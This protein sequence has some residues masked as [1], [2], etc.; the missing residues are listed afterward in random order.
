M[1]REEL[2]K[3][4]KPILFNTEMVKA[5]LDDCKTVTR[6]VVKLH[7]NDETFV[8]IKYLDS[9]YAVFS[10]GKSTGY[11]FVRLPCRPLD[12]LYVREAWARIC[13][14]CEYEP[15]LDTE[16]DCFP[17]YLYKAGWID[18]GTAP[19]WHPSI[20]MPKE[21]ARIFLRVM[22]VRVE[23]LQNIDDDGVV[24]EGLKIGAP[25]DELWN[26]TIKP[27]DRAIYGWDAN[28]WVWVIEFRKV[29]VEK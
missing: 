5:I 3:T 1:N 28:P 21:A 13:D 7:A 10:K 26:S 24:A 4:A 18:E 15:E 11:E 17:K 29:E 20:H 19:K 14:W 6:R 27:A 12:I 8:G 16:P 2:L 25:F 23:R 9:P 22:D